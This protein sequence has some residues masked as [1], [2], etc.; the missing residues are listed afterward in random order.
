MSFDTFTNICNFFNIEASVLLPLKPIPNEKD[1][2]EMVQISNLLTRCTPKQRE[3]I[4][5]TLLE[6]VQ[7]P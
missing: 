2:D 6:F 1:E 3:I 4:L 5:Q 7:K